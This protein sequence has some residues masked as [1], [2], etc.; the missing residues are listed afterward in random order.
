MSD[1]LGYPAFLEGLD[2]TGRVVTHNEV[3]SADDLY[4]IHDLTPV[5]KPPF[6][7]RT[8]RLRG[9][10][11]T[12]PIPINLSEWIHV[13]VDYATARPPQERHGGEQ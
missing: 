10:K 5:V 2:E 11:Q 6:T 1:D 3:H 8:I 12:I 7:V 9:A 4:R 13:V